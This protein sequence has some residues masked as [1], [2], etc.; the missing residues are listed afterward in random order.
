MISRWLFA[1]RGVGS[2]SHRYSQPGPSELPDS[3]IDMRRKCAK[4][5][6][7]LNQYAAAAISELSQGRW[8]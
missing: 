6:G 1:R 3:G 7:Y 4:G 2:S 5:S 8:Q